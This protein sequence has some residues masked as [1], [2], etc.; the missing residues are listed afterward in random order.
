MKLVV[1]A[2]EGVAYF[3]CWLGYGVET[4]ELGF[5]SWQGGKFY[6][7]SK[8]SDWLWGLSSFVFNGYIGVSY[9]RLKRPHHP[10]LWRLWECV[11]VN[12]HFQT[13]LRGLLPKY[14]QNNSPFTCISGKTR[15]NLK[16]TTNSFIFSTIAHVF[17]FLIPF[18]HFTLHSF[19]D[20]FQLKTWI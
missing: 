11:E 15:W 12:L 9:W 18:A 2:G 8:H 13:C 7:S 5:N 10:F 17:L 20:I 14:D 1:L 4:A 3:V 16:G 19:S 6:P